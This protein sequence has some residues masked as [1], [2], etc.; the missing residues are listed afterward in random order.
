MGNENEYL[1]IYIYI[2][3]YLSIYLEWKNLL[4]R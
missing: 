3:K 4:H 2:Y 1:Y